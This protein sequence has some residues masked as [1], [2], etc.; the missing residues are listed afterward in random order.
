MEESEVIRRIETFLKVEFPQIEMH[1]GSAEVVEY[2]HEEGYAKVKLDDACSGCGISPMT[3][4]ALKKRMPKS[5]DAINKVD[6]ETGD[7]TPDV[8][9]GPF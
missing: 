9:S 1:G 5:I 7:P 2:D 4:Q 8:T 3:I 6:A